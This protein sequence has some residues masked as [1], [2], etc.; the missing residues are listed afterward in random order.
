[1]TLEATLAAATFPTKFEELIFER[2]DA[3]PINSPPIR[4]VIFAVVM[5]LMFDVSKLETAPFAAL[6]NPVFEVDRKSVV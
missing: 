2:P 4:V 1:V 5:T 3:L 6:R